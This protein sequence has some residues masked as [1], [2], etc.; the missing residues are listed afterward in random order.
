M[1]L[2]DNG[3][4]FEGYCC[5][6]PL[7]P[8]NPMKQVVSVSSSQRQGNW[9]SGSV[10]LL[11]KPRVELLRPCSEPPH[12]MAA[13]EESEH[14][15]EHSF[16][17]WFPYIRFHTKVYLPLLCVWALEHQIYSWDHLV[18]VMKKHKRYLELVC[19]RRHE[20][21]ACGW[22]RSCPAMERLNGLPKSTQNSI[23]RK[24]SKIFSW[25][26]GSVHM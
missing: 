12:C 9:S 8:R 15:R 25:K 11:M 18:H 4:E 21:W 3:R 17:N 1:E 14:D 10:T 16:H 26:E 2:L 23:Y 24:G 19:P 5:E 7:S 22:M 13:M 6:S 20:P